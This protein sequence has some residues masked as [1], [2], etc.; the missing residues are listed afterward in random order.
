MQIL[1]VAFIQ[2]RTRVESQGKA[3]RQAVSYHWI[4]VQAR[5]WSVC[6]SVVQAALRLQLL[7]QSANTSWPR[8]LST[9]PQPRALALQCLRTGEA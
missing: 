1:H 7:S 9:H 2:H 4:N 5:R 3:F 8:L 6:L